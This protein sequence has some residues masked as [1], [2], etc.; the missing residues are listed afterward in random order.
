TEERNSD[1]VKR[2]KISEKYTLFFVSL[3]EHK[4]KVDYN[5][6]MQLLRYMVY[7]WE[8][9]ER[10]MERQ[11][12]GISRTKGFRYPPILPIVYYEGTGKWTA[13]RDLQDRILFDKAFE[14]FTPNF[15]YKLIELN[16]YSLGDLVEKNDELSLVMLINR[17][18]SS[19]EFR[20]LNLP[21]D[22]IKNLSE[23]STDELLDIIARV[24][25]SMLRHLNL[26]E[27][28]VAEFTGQVKERKMAELFE[29]FKDVDIPAARRKAMKEGRAEGLK[30]GLEQGLEQG[31]A[32]GEA[33]LAKLVR[34]LI[35]SNRMSDLTKALDNS[36]YRENLYQQ[37]DI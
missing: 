16:S 11:H 5:V 19:T 10:E 37:Y 30:Q 12:K 13:A 25:S 9:Y 26:P 15:F 1:T 20:E 14:P 3:I 29:N 22:Y 17:L 2:I 34:N 27:D 8:D 7:I 31:I 35:Q 21:E 28:E 18:Q 32:E 4:T 24:T 6:S 23:H 33:R 36:A